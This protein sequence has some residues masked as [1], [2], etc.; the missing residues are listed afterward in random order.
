MTFKNLSHLALELRITLGAVGLVA[1]GVPACA[2]DDGSPDPGSGAA[3]SAGGGAGV[4]STAG[5]G[6]SNA[7]GGSFGSG[8]AS[9]GKAGSG[10]GGTG[11]SGPGTGGS[12]PG[13]GGATNGG[14]A[15]AST[16]GSTGATAGAGPNLAGMGG[17]GSGNLGGMGPGGSGNPGGNGGAAGG[18]A[19][20][21]PLGPDLTDVGAFTPA[22]CTIT[23]T[24]TPASK[25]P[26][27]GV[28][29]FT[30][31]L[32]GADRAIIQF[33][34]TSEYTL[35]APVNWAAMNHQTLLLGMPASTEV[36]YR[37]VVFQGNNACVG[38]DAT[39]MTGSAPSGTPARVMPQRGM[40]SSE[41]AKGFIISQ[42]AQYSFI[43]NKEGEVVWAY[44]F[45]VSLTRSLMSWDGNYMLA[46]DIGPFNA[47]SGGSIYRVGMDGNGEMKLNV[48]GGHHHDFVTTPTGI[49]YFGKTAAGQCDSLYTANID[50]SNSKV[51]VDLDVVFSKFDDGP[52][53]ASMEKCHVN[54]IRYY[55]DTDSFSFSDREKDVIAL[56]SSSGE[57]LGSI[58]A[59]PNGSTPNHVRAEG[60]DSTSNSTWRVQHGHDHYEANKLVVFSNGS[61]Q[62]GQSRVLHYTINGS[63]AT[64]DWQYSGMGNSPTFSD[65][66][67]LPNGNFLGTASQGGNVHEVDSSGQLVVSF[68]GLCRGGYPHHRPT[69]YGPPPGR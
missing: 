23:P 8:G 59:E 1:L 3:T 18:G 67:Y 2:S 58:G 56:V 40:S 53:S 36:H 38:P 45:P 34:K 26:M 46:R 30:T 27:V 41:P 64:L 44:R 10:S 43:V 50:G 63:T 60:A 68:N 65:A 55:K 47:G 42:N 21:G 25:I 5:K 22:T 61:F 33:G 13:T 54:A 12:A 19:G 24:V 57:V 29:T 52:G 11:G 16:A 28:A 6:G 17:G 51:V 66:Q 15:G 37:V 9:A 49:A 14:S 39:Y 7:S 48:S 35:E 32:A 31:D 4:A 69:L 20:S 62:G